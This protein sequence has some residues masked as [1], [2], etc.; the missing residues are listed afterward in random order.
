M[1]LANIMQGTVP[2]YIAYCIAPIPI[3]EMLVFRAFAFCVAITVY[4]YIKTV[5]KQLGPVACFSKFD[6]TDL[7]AI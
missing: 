4:M 6:Y 7:E 1:P 2:S 5:S 3:A